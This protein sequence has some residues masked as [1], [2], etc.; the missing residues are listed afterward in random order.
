MSK[1]YTYYDDLK[2]SRDA[3]NE[4]IRA[5]YKALSLKYHPDRYNRQQSATTRLR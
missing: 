2:I 3:P 1:I 5:A 4:V